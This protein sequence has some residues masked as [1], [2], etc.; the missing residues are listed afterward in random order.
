LHKTDHFPLPAYA[1]VLSWASNPKVA[2]KFSTA[3]MEVTGSLLRWTLFAYDDLLVP[4]LLARLLPDGLIRF[5]AGWSM[6]S[7]PLMH[8]LTKHV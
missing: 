5:N 2:A 8:R 7:G 3:Y 4:L 6:C 1:Q